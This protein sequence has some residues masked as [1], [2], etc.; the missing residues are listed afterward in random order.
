MMGFCHCCCCSITQSCPTPCDP[1]DCSLPGSS[2]HG[3]FQARILERVAIS[4]SR[5][6]SR[7]R[8]RTQVSHLAGRHFTLSATREAYKKQG[9]GFLKTNV[10][11]NMPVIKCTVW[12]L[13]LRTSQLHT[14]SVAATPV[15][16]HVCSCSVASYSLQPQGW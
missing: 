15:K 12:G 1:T 11:Q 3:I 5:G 14:P 8:D 7:P 4:F 6:S 2:I 13:G 16:I 9:R 10:E